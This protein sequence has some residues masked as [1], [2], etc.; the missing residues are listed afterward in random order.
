MLKTKAAPLK[1]QVRRLLDELPDNFTVEDLQSRL[2]LL[3]KINRSED[4]L[5]QQG[6]IPHENIK[7][8]FAKWLAK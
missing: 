7:K 2:F 8:R 5:R 3:D 6:G 4:A 1:A